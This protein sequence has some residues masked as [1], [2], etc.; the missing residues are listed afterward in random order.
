MQIAKQDISELQ[1]DLKDIDSLKLELADFFCEDA[2]SFK[3]EECFNV[4]NT[5][6]ARFKK[7][8]S[9][10]F[11]ICL[12]F[13]LIYIIA[14]V[15]NESHVYLQLFLCYT[16][17]VRNINMLKCEKYLHVEMWEIL[18]CWNCCLDHFGTKKTFILSYTY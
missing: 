6:C 1:E 12:Y 3:L 7:A 2:S 5:F 13:I 16:A 18:T 17:N 11:H 9:V 10:S 8:I 4:L 14:Y 15:R